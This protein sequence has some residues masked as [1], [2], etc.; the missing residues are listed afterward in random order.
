MSKQ[1]IDFGTD[2]EFTPA[3]PAQ[4]AELRNAL[5]PPATTPEMEAGTET[6]PRSMSPAN[7][8][9]AIAAKSET[10]AQL[11]GRDIANRDR[12]NHTG[13]QAIASVSGLQSEL[14][15]KQAAMPAASQ[16]EMEAGTELGL[17]SMSPLRVRQAIQRL[18]YNPNVYWIEWARAM[19]TSTGGTGDILRQAD[20]MARLTTGPTAGSHAAIGWGGNNTT[21]A[22]RLRSKNS[23]A[24]VDFRDGLSVLFTLG[25][26][27]SSANSKFVASLFRRGTAR[28]TTNPSFNSRNLGF[29]AVGSRWFA[30]WW[31]DGDAQPNLVDT[32]V[33][34]AASQRMAIYCPPSRQVVWRI[35]E[36]AVVN[37]DLASPLAGVAQSSAFPAIE[38][39]N[40]TDEE[41]LRMNV[42]DFYIVIGAE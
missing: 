19:Q 37:L 35:N 17:R 15:G 14:D 13:T 20:S 32:G 3:T 5:L 38:L 8:A 6:D 21:Y 22:H 27:Q 10:T 12:A 11:N 34:L 40:D 9:E 30:A 1:P 16:S 7:V 29:A 26:V 36:T 25:A 18:A 2:P 24:S 31:G 41:D 33:D 39:L 42:G 4:R 23:T 28:A